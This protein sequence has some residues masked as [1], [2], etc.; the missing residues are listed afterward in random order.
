VQ[1]DINGV[2]SRGTQFRFSDWSP[3][4]HA[5]DDEAAGRTQSEEAKR[6]LIVE[7]DFLIA[8]EMEAALTEA[9]FEVVGVVPTGEEALELAQARAL[10]LAVMDIKLA[11]D[12][13]GVDS[14][15]EL[16][17][18][19]GVRSVFA[20][21][22]SDPEIRLRADPAAPLGWLQKPYTMTALT[23]MVRQAVNELRKK[24]R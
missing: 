5:P 9:G 1:N 16:F 4:L 13:D 14:A 11:G 8:S 7:D 23:A 10:T 21:A 20:S 2:P 22:Y 18:T 6:V 12:F 15:L 17:R 3:F 19:H 24:R